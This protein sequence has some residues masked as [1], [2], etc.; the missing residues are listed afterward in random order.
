V[1]DRFSWSAALVPPL[2]ALVHGLWLMLAIWV[3][4]VAGLVL[5]SVWIGA[6]ASFWLYVLAAIWLGFAAAGF[7]R[8]KAEAAGRYAGEWI[9]EGEDDALVGYL[10]GRA[11]A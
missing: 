10:K 7:R 4:K 1:A 9:A 8:R 11:A 3:A 6:E 2:H 5:V